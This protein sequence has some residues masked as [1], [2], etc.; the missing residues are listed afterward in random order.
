[1]LLKREEDKNKQYQPINQ[2]ASLAAV[3]NLA[4]GSI[5]NSKE[6]LKRVHKINSRLSADRN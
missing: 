2:S 4:I 3:E 6:D 1:M 5:N